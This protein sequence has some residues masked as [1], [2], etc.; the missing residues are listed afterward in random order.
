MFYSSLILEMLSKTDMLPLPKIFKRSLPNGDFPARF[1]CEDISDG[2]VFQSFGTD[3]TADTTIQA[4]FTPG[5]TDDHV[6]FLVVEDSALISG[7]C[8]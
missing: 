2:Q 7:D 6:S 4:L 3:G 5:H 1:R 8:M